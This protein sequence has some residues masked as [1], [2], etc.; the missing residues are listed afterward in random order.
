MKTP[1]RTI[2]ARQAETV[3]PFVRQ[4]VRWALSRYRANQKIGVPRILNEIVEALGD[5]IS[6]ELSTQDI[7]NF[8]DNGRETRPH[9]VR[10]FLR[11]LEHKAPDYVRSISFDQF[12]ITA[13]DFVHA[14]SSGLTSRK[15]EAAHERG[16][17]RFQTE[18]L[19]SAKK[20]G[21]LDDAWM[22]VGHQ[23]EFLGV[24]LT[25]FAL[26]YPGSG[27]H[28]LFHSFNLYLNSGYFDSQRLAPTADER[29]EKHFT[30]D[31][32]AATK[33]VMENFTFS[34]DLPISE[35]SH[36][37]VINGNSGDLSS[38][39]GPFLLMRRGIEPGVQF[40]H[41]SIRS[42]KSGPYAGE[43]GLSM[44]RHFNDDEED[45]F[46]TRKVGLYP[47]Y[48]MDYLLDE[49]VGETESFNSKGSV[50][51]IPLKNSSLEEFIDGFDWGNV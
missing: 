33:E 2:A 32:L 31:S 37:V 39:E 41:C 20:N 27:S 49:L 26:R 17:G 35:K 43:F 38:S 22:E 9:K 36:G 51:F 45:T 28:F 21:N 44:K 3:T 7:Y 8:L 30:L 12:A 40:E 18:I 4:Q 14:Y 5:G 50:F 6:E 16:L 24:D 46:A 15:D 13:A 48:S 25:I 1:L 29:V 10:L 23:F 34:E 47:M 19:F 11:F 42:F